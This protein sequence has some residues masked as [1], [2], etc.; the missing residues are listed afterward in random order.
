[1]SNS[2]ITNR[3]ENRIRVACT[4]FKNFVAQAVEIVKQTY[5]DHPTSFEVSS[6]VKDAEGKVCTKIST[7]VS[8]EEIMK[9]NTTSLAPAQNQPLTIA[10]SSP[11]KLT[12]IFDKAELDKSF[13][14]V[15]SV[16]SAEEIFDKVP[17]KKANGIFDIKPNLFSNSGDP[18]SP[19]SDTKQSSGSSIF[20]TKSVTSPNIFTSPNISLAWP[21]THSKT[22]STSQEESESKAIGEDESHI[23]ESKWDLPEIDRTML[24]EKQTVSGEES[25]DIVFEANCK[26]LKL[27]S[28][29]YGG[30]KRSNFWQGYGK[31]SLKILK[32][33]Q[34]GKCRCVG[35]QDKT[36]K[37]R[38]N[39]SLVKGLR[40]GEH[41]SSKKVRQVKAPN[42][43][44]TEDGDCVSKDETM[45]FRFKSEEIAL[46][47][48]SKFEAIVEGQT[49]ECT[50]QKSVDTLN[51]A[52][53]TSPFATSVLQNSSN[54]VQLQYG[55][56]TYDRSEVIERLTKYYK[57]H[58]ET[59][60]AGIASCVEKYQNSSTKFSA[61]I[62]AIEKKYGERVFSDEDSIPVSGL[63]SKQSDDAPKE[64]SWMNAPIDNPFLKTNLSVSKLNSPFTGGPSN[65]FANK[66]KTPFT[67]NTPE[68]TQ[69]T[70]HDAFQ[71]TQTTNFQNPFNLVPEN[72]EVFNSITPFA[73]TK[74][75]SLFTNPYPNPF[76]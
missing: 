31:H 35:R 71:N 42:L 72:K 28:D 22:P 73:T 57:R 45:A 12:S 63:S 53:V 16:F 43:V 20:G 19:L 34:T 5:P 3:D 38:V 27:T 56:Q 65:L 2:N 15:P 1:M 9:K 37:V 68:S 6:E 59:K 75:S 8:Y 11:R 46:E 26:L 74:D 18:K 40:V 14:K 66:E 4:R 33:R 51:E 17:S 44:E 55:G 69:N 13:D 24:K 36:L 39:F 30:E 32:D 41:T 62:D 54:S 64:T 58:D 29:E 25:E 48:A 52:E 49:Q 23:D 60:V 47:F 7:I 70:T 61:Y 21:D 50:P 10:N 76:K 67:T